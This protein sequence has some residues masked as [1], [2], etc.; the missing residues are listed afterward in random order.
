LVVCQSS[1]ACLFEAARDGSPEAWQNAIAHTYDEVQAILGQVVA[2]LET[3]GYSHREVFSV[4][5]SLEEA[6]V[7]AI[8][9]GHRGDPTKDVRIRFQITPAF[10][11]AEV[12]DEGPGFDPEAVPD[13][14]AEENRLSD[15]GRGLLLMRHYMTCVRYNATGNRVTLCK[16][17]GV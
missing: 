8:K 17:R 11:L 4:R 9:H 2:A 5:L 12:E 15:H 16:R 1:E 10:T 6:M 14:L 7:N 13:P 3:A